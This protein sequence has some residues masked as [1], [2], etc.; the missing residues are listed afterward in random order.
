MAKKQIGTIPGLIIAG[1]V[2]WGVITLLGGFPDVSSGDTS[3]QASSHAAKPAPAVAKQAHQRWQYQVDKD[4]MTGKPTRFAMLRST[5]TFALDFPYR[6]AQHST[7]TLRQ[8]AQHGFD[9]IVSIERGQLQCGI[10]DGCKL[11]VRFDDGPPQNWTFVEPES[12][13]S[14]VLFLRDGKQFAR[15]VSSSKRIRIEL[16]FFSQSPEV[17]TFGTAGLDRKQIGL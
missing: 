5:N 7:L 3:A 11:Q 12:H 16:K 14:T 4:Q 10:S 15:K 13:E 17:V 1:L 2:L 9:S 8:H 6:G